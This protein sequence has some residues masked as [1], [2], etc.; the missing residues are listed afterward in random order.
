VQVDWCF[1]YN[2]SMG[3][4]RCVC[5]KAGDMFDIVGLGSGWCHTSLAFP[6]LQNMLVG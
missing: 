6:V 4:H 1:G 2:K 3:T 5:V